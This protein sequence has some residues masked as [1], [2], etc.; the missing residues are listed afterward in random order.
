VEWIDVMVSHRDARS[1][2][3]SVL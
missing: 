1:A 2:R 3:T